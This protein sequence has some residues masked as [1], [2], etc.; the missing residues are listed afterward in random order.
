MKYVVW[1]EPLC[2]D[3]DCVINSIRRATEEDVI[4]LMKHNFPE[5]KYSDENALDDFVIVNWA[6][7]DIIEDN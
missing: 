6:W 7:F 1:N 5:R 3:T 4:K 2:L